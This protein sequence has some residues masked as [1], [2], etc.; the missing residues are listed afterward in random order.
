MCIGDRVRNVRNLK[1]K[2]IDSS[3]TRVLEAV[4]LRE[5]MDQMLSLIHI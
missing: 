4:G 3:V 2:D 5:T 1:R